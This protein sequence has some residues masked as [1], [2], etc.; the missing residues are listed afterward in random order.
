MSNSKIADW[1]RIISASP[2]PKER[3][4]AMNHL[5]F[6]IRN[7]DTL[8]AI[9]LCREALKLSSEI[10][11]LEG[12]AT[13]LANEAFCYVQITDYDL[14]LEKLFEALRIF[15]EIKNEEGLARVRYN[16]CLVY[17]RFSDFY[18]GL[19]NIG[20]AFSYY[21][22]MG[23]K[24]EMARC[25]FQ[26]GYLYQSLGDY[27]SALEYHHASLELNREIANK[28]GEAAA[29]MGIG[30]TNIATKEFEVSRDYLLK[31]LKLREEIQD[32]RGYAASLN[33]Y[34]TLCL[35]TGQN[36]E[37]EEISKKGIKL[38][39]K[40]GDKMGISRFMLDLGKIYF[41]QNKTDE[42]ERVLN[43]SLIIADKIN[44]RMA[45]APLH[46]ALSELYESKRDYKRALDHFRKFHKV[47]EE[48]VNIDAAMKAK[49]AQFESKI[50]SSKQDAEINRLKNVELKNAYNEIAEKNKDI[51]DSINYAK[52]IQQAKL[53]TRNDILSTLPQ[54]FV[55]FKPKDIVSGDFY[56]FQNHSSD[57]FAQG[58]CFIAAADCT[59]H[60]VPGAFM[61]MIGSERLE[62]AV[63]QSKDPGEILQVLNRGMKA[64][65]R[66]SGSED[67]TRDGMDIA[68]CSIFQDGLKL[69][70]AGA[71]RPLLR[72]RRDDAGTPLLFECKPT[73]CAIGGHTHDD[74]IFET[75]ELHMKKGDTYYLFT[76]GY[77]DQFNGQNA[78][79]LMIKKFKEL[80]VAIHHLSMK[81][82][83]KHLDEFIDNWK[84]GI[85]QVDD[86]LVIGI[87]I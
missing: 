43:E 27:K 12:E 9:S 61:S 19:E 16:L 6:E 73:K 76:D 51:T 64:S 4:D 23:D 60:G 31:S 22:K 11:Y 13:A 67:S 42:G 86:I 45:L 30:Q 40:L 28:A 1:E 69:Y 52:R 47:K 80:L 65:L 38:A 41:K 72:V 10:K 54:S 59:G 20:K 36:D 53:P 25:Y 78:K 56:F 24:S 21:E 37:A 84:S 18:R 44:L 39:T 35:E 58:S 57:S 14:A 3:V 71:N 63:S 49:S 85:D 87:K 33:A 5:A 55:L 50:E 17:F 70:Y 29:M 68:L 15:E 81:D 48:M 2:I 74:Q 82:Q 7:A 79:K 75:H 66:Q 62:D 77:A 32:W 46:L 26:M 83:E 34:M 8:R